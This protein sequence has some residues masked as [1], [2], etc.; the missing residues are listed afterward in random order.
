MKFIRS[1]YIENRFFLS[2]SIV[3]FV[4]VVGYVFPFFYAFGKMALIVLAVLFVLDVLLL[5]NRNKT[6]MTGMRKLPIRFSNGDDNKVVLAIKN[7]YSFMVKLSIIDELPPQFQQRDFLINKTLKPGQGAD[8]VY[9]VKPVERGQ[10]FFGVMNVFCASP[11][12]LVARRFKLATEAE[13]AVYP[14]Y[15]QLKKFEFLAMSNRL[16]ELGVKKIR[17]ISANAEFDQLRNYVVG[18]DPRTIN[19]K[20]TAKKN[21]LV[22]NQFMDEKS[23]PVYNIIDCSR[24]MKMPFEGMSLLE[25]AINSALVVSNIAL[26]KYDRAGLLCFSKDVNSFLPADKKKVYLHKIHESLYKL[27]TD[28]LEANYE[29]L[30]IFVRTR[31]K[32]RS[33]LILYTNFE[34]MN[35]AQRQLKYLKNLAYYHLVLLVFFENTEIAQLGET[36]GPSLEDIYVN[37]IAHKFLFE[38]KRIIKELTQHGIHC[39]YTRPEN[40]SV[41]TINKYLEFK[42]RGLI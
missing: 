38:K 1:L 36:P 37:T 20:A 34:S 28:F 9:W 32:Q 42:A 14:S 39:I 12:G 22:V 18:D 16:D 27:N 33:L 24:V 19:W 15:I 25:Y 6:N 17:K 41:A 4:V 31:I 5:Y 10:Y 8:L 40:L 35:A 30:S 26:N 13:V 11:V 21:Q 7:N 29:L 3:V 2:I 23:Q